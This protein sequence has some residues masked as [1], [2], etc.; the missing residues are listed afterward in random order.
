MKQYV[1]NLKTKGVANGWGTYIVPGRK[2]I[3]G[4]LY[5]MLGSKEEAQ[6]FERKHNAIETADRFLNG[7]WEN[8]YFFDE[9][10][11][12]EVYD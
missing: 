8:G 6:R 5:R 7:D 2:K 9:Y 4:S 3:G 11:V 12:E 1:I 10:K